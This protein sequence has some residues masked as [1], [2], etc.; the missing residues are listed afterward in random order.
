MASGTVVNSSGGVL[1]FSGGSASNPVVRSG[2]I[3]VD[4]GALLFTNAGT[5]TFGGILSAGGTVIEAGSGTLVLRGNLTAFSGTETISHGTLELASGGAAGSGTIVFAGTGTKLKIDGTVMPTNVISGFTTGEIINLAS[6]P[7]AAGDTA[8]YSGTTLSIKNS[9]GTV[10]AKLTIAGSH[11]T[12]S[13]SLSADAVSGIDIKDPVT[14]I[15]SSGVTSTGLTLNSGDSMNVL[16]GGTAVATAVNSGGV[17]LDQGVTSGTK[18]SGGGQ[19]LVS[20]GG[21]ARD[22]VLSTDTLASGNQ[23]VFAG[24]IVRGTVVSLG[25]QETISSGGVASGTVLNGGEQVVSSGGVAS[26]TVVGFGGQET[27]SAGG[28]TS[29]TVV[30]F[31]GHE[32]VSSGGVARGTILSAGT[33]A[34]VPA[35][36]SV[37]A[38]GIA[39]GTLVSFGGQETISS[40][41]VARNAVVGSDGRV[42]VRSGGVARGTVVSSGGVQFV[43]AGGTARNSLVNSGGTVIDKGALVFTSGGTTTFA[44]TLSGGGSVTEAGN[45]TLAMRGDANAF[46]GT[47]TISQGTLELTSG[48]AAGSGTILFAGSGTKLKIDGTAIP[49]NVISGFT[50]GEVIDLADIPFTSG[51]TATYDGTTLS[52]KNSGGTV[53]AQLTIAGTHTASSFSL[54]ADPIGG[55][56]I[57]TTV[58][59]VPCFA[60]GTLIRTERGD[61][62]VESLSLGDR[63]LTRSDAIAAV[64]WIGRRQ[65]N[66]SRHPDPARVWPVRVRQD[67]FADGIPARD[68][69][70]SPD[71]AVFADGVLI[72]IKYLINRTTIVQE[73]VAH[74]HY[75][76]VE[77]DRHN[78]L[79]ANG[80]AAESYLDTGNREQF[81]G[82]AEYISL[83]PDFSPLSWENA[84]LPLCTEGPPLVAF[85]RRLRERVIEL[86]GLHIE[87]GGRVI[88]PAVVRGR[89]IRFLLPAHTSEV[90]IESHSAV[91][92]EIE[93][94]SPDLRCLGVRI[95][96]ILIAG[97][98]IPLDS[99]LLGSGFHPIERKGTEAWRWT[100]GLATL[101][102]PDPSPHVMVLELLA[103]DAMRCW[104]A[105]EPRSLSLTA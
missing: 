72:P 91:R 101:R 95:G 62:P 97:R 8:T 21:V 40:G 13:F 9:G 58:A 19:E 73:H 57:T 39:R 59:T 31:G 44:G 28:V 22:T 85:R 79:F 67:A 25:G 3:V 68:L 96:S 63:V 99:P 82:G 48:G 26:R 71:H 83:H 11:T 47:E 38:G 14:I 2:G 87:T 34:L 29:R 89:L 27:I 51:D 16:S 77:L 30:L 24:G 53:L 55:I 36:Q 88:R 78:V 52:V 102:L 76:H 46:S 105:P 93:Q 7:F 86:A 43:S 35:D 10:L 103:R 12:S 98:P 66:C 65:V 104:I 50:I 100:D 5:A 75:F 80:L 64:V 45:G 41:G 61:V 42:S 17:V 94:G 54:S 60:A 70:L 23:S 4:S 49:T 18:V 37:F 74:V 92:A 84:C 20:S 32:L 6:I 33:L 69:W 1:V 81:E 15:V 90:R 56:D